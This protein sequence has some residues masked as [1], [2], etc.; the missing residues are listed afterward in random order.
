MF[1]FLAMAT[2]ELDVPKSM[3]Q[4]MLFILAARSCLI[5]GGKLNTLN[6]SR[7]DLIKYLLVLTVKG[8]MTSRQLLY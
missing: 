2:L 7:V 1:R 3:P 8:R 4:E 5:W 6:Y